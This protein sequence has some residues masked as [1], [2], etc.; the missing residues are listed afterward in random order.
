M[1]NPNPSVKTCPVC[2]TGNPADSLFCISC[3]T[4]FQASLRGY[5]TVVESDSVFISTGGT[6]V[7]YFSGSAVWQGEVSGGITLAF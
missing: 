4:R 7:A 3:G 2:R 1:Q 5:C 6:T